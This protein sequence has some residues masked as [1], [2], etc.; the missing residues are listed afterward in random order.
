MILGGF[1]SVILYLLLTI[2]VYILV[3]AKSR[4]LF[5]CAAL[6]LSAGILLVLPAIIETLCFYPNTGYDPEQRKWLFFYDPPRITAL[7]L[8]IPSVFGN[9]HE[10]R[11]A[12]MRDF[13]GS[14]LGAGI[15]TFPLAF[16]LLI[17]AVLKKYTINR[18]SIFWISILGFCLMAY[19]NL[20]EIKQALKYIPI[21][22]EH[23]FTRLQSLI[24]L[25]S[26]TSAA[27]LIEQLL[28]RGIKAAQWYMLLSFVGVSTLGVYT[29]SANLL[30]ADHVL[31]NIITYGIVA[32]LSILTL[33]WAILMPNFTA[34]LPFVGMNIILGIATSLSYTY[35]FSPE[36]Y[37]PERNE[38]TYMKQNLVAG[39]RVLDVHDVLFQQTA[40]AYGIPS[41]TNHWFT[42]PSL[43]TWVHK[44]SSDKPN[45]G[46]TLDTIKSINNK[47][48]WGQLRQMHVQFVSLPYTR[49]KEWID[50]PQSDDWKIVTKNE[51][52]IAI[53]EVL[54]DGRRLEKL[55]GLTGRNY[56]DYVEYSGHIKFQ[57]TAEG[58][59]ITI[60]VRMH[61]GW[62]IV[63]GAI[64]I[65][66]DRRHLITVLSSANAEQIE[67]EY[68]PRNFY[69]WLAIGP[70]L[71][72]IFSSLIVYSERRKRQSL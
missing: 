6:A 36:D 67:L 8:V 3:M 23:P 9:I 10:Y 53:L 72:L 26:A 46:L 31:F 61:D 27:L 5:I 64:T 19:F 44:L 24:T 49:N 39:A 34:G 13:Y 58:Q 37:Y 71:L 54:F 45:K 48:V 63:K 18:E 70:M 1:P 12:G 42:P 66:E 17:Y 52:D 4:K 2:G 29:F 56:S 38:I 55:Q 15:L 21:L 50:I 65:A 51:N 30:H 33:A 40:T 62:H 60:P 16:I 57:P 25:A 43:R 20:F 41:V 32:V 14:L 7:N 28:R 47:D 11:N 69:L 35:Y 22:N 59:W 68:A